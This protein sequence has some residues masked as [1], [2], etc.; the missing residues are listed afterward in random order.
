MNLKL[1]LRTLAVVALVAAT[2]AMIVQ[3][4]SLAKLPAG[5]QLATVPMVGLGHI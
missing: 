2:M 3:P 4:A 1:T 5:A